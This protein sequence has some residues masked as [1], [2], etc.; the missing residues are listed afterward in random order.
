MTA[1]RN[2]AAMSWPDANPAFMR[3]R[4]WPPE[5]PPNR[6]TTTAPPTDFSKLSAAVVV[7]WRKGRVGS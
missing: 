4:R 5:Q 2:Y 7:E 3:G 6:R 1:T